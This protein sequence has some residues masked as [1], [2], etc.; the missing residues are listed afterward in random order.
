MP[1]WPGVDAHLGLALSRLRGSH[2]APVLDRLSRDL[3]R[4]GHG[5]P[6]LFLV[7]QNEPGFELL[8][9]KGPGDRLRPEQVGWLDYLS[10]RGLPSA[11]LAVEWASPSGRDLLR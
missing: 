5:L 1:W 8:E 7:S 10:A 6:D 2:L 3:G 9:V 11:V 4:Y